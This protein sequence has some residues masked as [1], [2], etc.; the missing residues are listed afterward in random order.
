MMPLEE[1]LGLPGY[2]VKQIKGKGLCIFEVEY[3]LSETQC[4][5]KTLI[6]I[7]EDTRHERS[8]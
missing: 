4:I 1:I 5:K 2:K 6:N 8:M 7:I 3:V